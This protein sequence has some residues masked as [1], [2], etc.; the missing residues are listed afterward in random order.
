VIEIRIENGDQVSI[1]FLKADYKPRPLSWVGTIPIPE[2]LEIYDAMKKVRDKIDPSDLIKQK[3]V[4]E[5]LE[6]LQRINAE[7]KEKEIE[8][9]N[10][11]QD[12]RLEKKSRRRI[13]PN[14]YKIA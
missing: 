13:N 3:A 10:L 9:L 2:F 6:T 14:D 5:D 11:Q 4:L 8:L 7:L 12:P 1:N